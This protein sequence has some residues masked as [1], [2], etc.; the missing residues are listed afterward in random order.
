VEDCDKEGELTRGQYDEIVKL[1]DWEPDV[2]LKLDKPIPL[3][4]SVYDLIREEASEPVT[5]SEIR[6]CIEKKYNVYLSVAQGDGYRGYYYMA[7]MRNERLSANKCDGFFPT[8]NEAMRTLI[9][10]IE[11]GRVK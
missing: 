8:F 9:L 11:V 1:A 3:D 4:D 5:I 10:N 7:P 6:R 2:Q